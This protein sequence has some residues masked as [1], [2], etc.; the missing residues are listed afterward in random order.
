[1]RA[2]LREREGC[3]GSDGVEGA[4]AREGVESGVKR[5]RAKREG[6]EGSVG[7]EGCEASASEGEVQGARE[8]VEGGVKRAR[9]V[10]TRW[11]AME[12]RALR[13][14]GE[15]GARALRAR[16]DGVR[17]AVRAS[18]RRE[19]EREDRGSVDVAGSEDAGASRQASD[20]SAGV[21][22]WRRAHGGD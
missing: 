4:V 12:M 7:G 3:E 21:S 22:W 10:R 19:R 9:A 20:A 14:K 2:R 1:M 8:G 18:D 11:R 17:G 6:C 13:A 16:R 15:R 5:A